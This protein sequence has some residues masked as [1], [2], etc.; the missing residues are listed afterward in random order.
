MPT[1]GLATTRCTFLC[2]FNP[3]ACHLI[4]PIRSRYSGAAWNETAC[5]P[6]RPARLAAMKQQVSRA[7]ERCDRVLFLSTPASC[8]RAKGANETSGHRWPVTRAQPRCGPGCSPAGRLPMLLANLEARCSGVGALQRSHRLPLTVRPSP[9]ARRRSRVPVLQVL[10]RYNQRRN[11]SPPAC[12]NLPYACWRML[13]TLEWSSGG[14]GASIR[15]GA[16]R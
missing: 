15:S 8:G 13:R 6:R 1:A 3:I 11:L 4:A 2:D 9:S 12:V 14:S 5:R 7:A 16:R 10:P